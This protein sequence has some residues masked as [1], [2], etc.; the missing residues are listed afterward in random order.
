LWTGLL[1]AFGGTSVLS[2]PAAIFDTGGLS[3]VPHTAPGFGSY[4]EM[5]IPYPPVRT[6]FDAL[7]P[8]TGPLHSRGEAHITVITP[9][10]FQNVLSARLT[11]E[12]IDTIA[13]EESIQSSRFSLVCVGK[14]QAA[15]EGKS[16][17]T[18]Y[19][20]V[21][22][23][24]LVRIRHRIFDAY[25]QRGGEPSHFDPEA[26]DPHITVGFTRR[27]LQE[28]DGVFKGRNSCRYPVVTGP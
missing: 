20:I 14:A 11:I 21:A 6:L 12:A 15:I 22:S 8:F 25:V 27:D 5:E 23:P 10:E 26:F 16:E 9:P 24:D 17:S 1:P 7:A 28:S 18:Y 2:V 4:L 3:F 19:L 13:L